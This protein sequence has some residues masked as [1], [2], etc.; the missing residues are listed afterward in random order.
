MNTDRRKPGNRMRMAASSR[1][2]ALWLAL[3]LSV[4]ICGYLCSSVVP[5]LAG[6]TEV[7]ADVVLRG[8]MIVDGSGTDGVVGDVAIKD[9]RIVAV[10]KFKVKGKAKILDCDG[11]VIAPGFIDLHTHSDTEVG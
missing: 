6:D 9:D 11:L 2:S 10:G 4:F 5:V 3:P 7:E 1:A 8:G